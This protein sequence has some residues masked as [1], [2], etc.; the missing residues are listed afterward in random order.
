M[1]TL[2]EAIH[3][4]LS[5][6][7][8]VGFKIVQ[9]EGWLK[10]FAVFM[11]AKNAAWV[12]SKL[13]LQWAVL[14]AKGQPEYWAKRLMAVRCFARY[15]SATDPRTEIP[16]KWL[17]PNYSKRANPYLCSDEEI[18][19]LLTAAKALPSASGL[20]GQTYYCLLGLLIVTGIR[21]GEALALKRQD[22][23][24]QQG[25]LTIRG[26]KLGKSRLIPLHPSTREVLAQYAKLRDAVICHQVVDNFLVSVRG[27]VLLASNVRN[28]F[29][30][31]SCQTGLREPGVRNGPRLHDFRHR[32]A[33]ETLL[34]WYR[35]GEDIERHL[36][37]LSTFLGHSRPSDTYW[38]IS[39]CPELMEQA[40]RL[41]EKRW[42][43]SS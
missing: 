43:M 35:S 25:V 9:A 38:Y 34:R 37:E 10:D 29:Y 39:A 3:E 11:N 26:A 5:M 42:G 13:A 31:L 16:A 2:T 36:H 19:K 15:R 7:H 33:T 1:N 30:K 8:S 40:A 28:T 6:R 18:G 14:P 22:V 4:Y 27:E 17:L 23:D 21:I 12:T 24:L 20:R 32:F 41:L